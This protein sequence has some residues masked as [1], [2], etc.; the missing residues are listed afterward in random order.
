MYSHENI[1]IILPNTDLENEAI[2]KIS[3]DKTWTATQIFNFIQ[4]VNFVYKCNY[5]TAN[6]F[7]E[8]DLFLSEESNKNVTYS[9]YSQSPLVP[10][11]ESVK[12]N[13]KLIIGNHGDQDYYLHKVFSLPKMKALT[14]QL[15]IKKI[16]YASPGITDFLGVAGILK[17][18]KES[19]IYYFPNKHDKE[20]YEILKEQRTE[21]RI[22]NLKAIGF[23]DLE[24]RTLI[25][26]EDMNLDKLS[27][28]IKD[29]HITNIEI[30]EDKI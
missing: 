6:L 13:L 3:I 8:I 23:T 29:G 16:Q 9:I 12:S 15:I 22:K 2:L 14:D 5:W 4:S 11:I 18:I 24:I 19:L 1:K 10:F 27:D 30:L 26:R 20:Q 21:Q 7:N 17:E 28:F 25:L